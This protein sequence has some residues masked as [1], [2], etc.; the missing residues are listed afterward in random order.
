M[1]TD[2]RAGFYESCQQDAGV[3]NEEG[4]TTFIF[5]LFDVFFLARPHSCPPSSLCRF[6]RSVC[7]SRSLRVSRRSERPREKDRQLIVAAP[8]LKGGLSRKMRA[9]ARVRGPTLFRFA[10]LLATCEDGSFRSLTRSQLIPGTLLSAQRR[11]A[12]FLC[13]ARVDRQAETSEKIQCKC[14]N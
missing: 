1:E 3:R 9:R 6:S 12:V 11:R 14:K 13:P 4:V 10:C 8:F 7:L 5:V 2:A